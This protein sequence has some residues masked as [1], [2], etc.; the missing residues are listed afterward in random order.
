MLVKQYL[1]SG[2]HAQRISSGTPGTSSTLSGLRVCM[3]HTT[4]VWPK[5][6]MAASSFSIAPKSIM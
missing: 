6:F 1:W 4:M 3:S 2:S 5:R